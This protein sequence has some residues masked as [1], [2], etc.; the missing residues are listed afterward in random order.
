MLDNFYK[1]TKQ[2]VEKNMLISEIELN[3]SHRIYEGHFPNSPIVP[4]VCMIEI[5]QEV[6]EIERRKKT[7]L[8][9][10]SNIKFLNVINPNIHQIIFLELN[11]ECDITYELKVSAKLF[12][13][14][15]TFFKINAIFSEIH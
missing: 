2:Y 7:I 4:G 9:K 6:L 3:S 10:A 15:I 5:V 14:K 13:E 12:K 11:I 8:Q 1:I